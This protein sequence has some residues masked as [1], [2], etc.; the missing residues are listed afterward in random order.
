MRAAEISIALLALAPLALSQVRPSNPDVAGPYQHYGRPVTVSV[1]AI[2]DR[3][4]P[5][6]V[7]LGAVHTRGLFSGSLLNS[8]ARARSQGRPPLALPL[9]LMD[10]HEPVGIAI[11]PV[12]EIAEPFLDEAATL[13]CRRLEIVGTFAPDLGRDDPS[14]PSQTLRFWSYLVTPGCGAQKGE[15]PAL[16]LERVIAEIDTLGTREVR[17]RGQFRGRAPTSGVQCSDAPSTAWVIEDGPF[18]VWVYGREPRGPGW[19]LGPT[20][21]RAAGWW[22]EVTGRL[23]MKHDCVLLKARDVVLLS[24]AQ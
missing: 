9:T 4:V 14:L 6:V 22:L 21:A 18:E 15:P 5:T 7:L 16:P 23:F 11:S 24:R 19:S 8:A 3:L 10:E 2:H 1:A 20:D 17:V 12:P 13:G